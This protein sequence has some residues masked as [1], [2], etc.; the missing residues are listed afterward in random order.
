M[1]R[2]TTSRSQRRRLTTYFCTVLLNDWS[3][4]NSLAPNMTLACCWPSLIRGLITDC[5][6][7]F[8]C[9]SVVHRIIRLMTIHNTSTTKDQES[10]ELAV[11]FADMMSRLLG[12][13]FSPQEVK[14]KSHRTNGGSR[15][16]K[17]GARSSAAGAIIE[18]TKAPSGWSLGRGCPPPQWEWV[19][20]GGIA[21]RQK[22]FR[23]WV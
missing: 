19:W 4:G 16:C 22:I 15:I 18:A 3:V 1:K 11:R 10:P 5:T 7:S 13:M 20:K 2:R 17:R 21:P 14:G 23:F 12:H 9:M 8:V 6:P